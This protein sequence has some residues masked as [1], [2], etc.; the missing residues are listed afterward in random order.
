MCPFNAL[1]ESYVLLSQTHNSVLLSR[2]VQIYLF[3]LQWRSGTCLETWTSTET[4]SWDD[5][6]LRQCFPEQPDHSRE[7][8]EPV[9]GPLQ[10]PQLGLRSVC[11]LPSTSMGETPPSS[12]GIWCWSLRLPQALLSIDICWIIVGGRTK[13]VMANAT[14]MLM[15]LCGPFLNTLFPSIFFILCSSTLF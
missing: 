11:L 12:F 6:C 8:L 13:W 9:H 5:D 15:S 3:F 2:C 7:G 4:L 1:W 14:I 10:G